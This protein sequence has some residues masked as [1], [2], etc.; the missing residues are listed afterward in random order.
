VRSFGRFHRFLGDFENG[1][2]W[3]GFAD[4]GSIGAVA[5]RK[6]SKGS[7]AQ[8]EADEL[9]L[10]ADNSEK[11]P[12]PKSPRS[13]NDEDMNQIAFRTLKQATEDK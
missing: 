12:K 2:V 8:I 5:K 6:F 7:P 11:T 3:R 4:Y 13:P 9:K 10:Q 1:G